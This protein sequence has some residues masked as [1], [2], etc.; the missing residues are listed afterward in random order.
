M[1][2]L[3]LWVFAGLTLVLVAC[4]GGAT[5]SQNTRQVT[6]QVSE[7]KFEPATIEVSV[8]QP[9]KLTMQNK[10]SI[11]HDWAIM[12]IPMMGMKESGE[13]GHAM[14]AT[15]PDLH[16]SAMMG[17]SAELEFTPTQVGTYQIV[18]TVAGHKGAGMVGTLIVK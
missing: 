4:S 7:F 10:G 15:K 5:S 2:K 11:E 12:K 3:M 13:V 17:K 16:V 14:G 1:Q 18:C 8:G 6:V 9:V